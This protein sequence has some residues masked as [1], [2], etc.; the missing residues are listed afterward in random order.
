MWEKFKEWFSSDYFP[1]FMLGWCG[2][3][4]LYFPSF[5][6]LLLLGFWVWVLNAEY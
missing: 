3:S 6:N 2:A 1:W 5:I 4:L